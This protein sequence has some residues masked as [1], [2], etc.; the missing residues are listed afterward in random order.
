VADIIDTFDQDVP[1][2]RDE[3]ARRQA[4]EWAMTHSLAGLRRDQA[5]SEQFAASLP[6]ADESVTAESTDAILV[7][8]SLRIPLRTQRR[9]QE[10]AKALGVKPT[11][12]MRQWIE[13][14]LSTVDNDHPI[15]LQDALRVLAQLPVPTDRAAP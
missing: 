2:S 14:M 4:V 5:A 11:A 1:V 10:H 9:I 13:Q 7:T 15:S 8:T 6:T 3:A 12:L